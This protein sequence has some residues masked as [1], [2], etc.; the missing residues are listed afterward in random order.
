[1]AVHTVVAIAATNNRPPGNAM[2]PP[3]RHRTHASHNAGANRTTEA[4]PSRESHELRHC[5]NARHARKGWPRCA[6]DDSNPAITISSPS[7]I[8][9][10]AVSGRIAAGVVIECRPSSASR[11]QP[12]PE[13][14]VKRM[15]ENAGCID[16][17][18]FHG[19]AGHRHHQHAAAVLHLDG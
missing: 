2:P 1:M 18:E 5:E 6:S 9:G 3:P 7:P 14:V 8:A 17:A 19:R 16:S 4:T 12:V 10:S 13:S 15:T 11:P